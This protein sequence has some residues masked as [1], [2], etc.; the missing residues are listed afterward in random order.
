MTKRQKRRLTI[1]LV[2]LFILLLA[3]FLFGVM[4][5]QNQVLKIL[6]P[7]KYADYVYQYAEKNELDP[8]LVFAIIKAESNFKPEVISTSNAMGL[9]QLVDSTAEDTAKKL[10]IPYEGKETLLDPEKNIMLGTKY[11]TDLLAKYDNVTI[12]LTAYNAGSGNVDKWIA[13]GTIKEDGSNAENIPF[14]ETNHYV[15]KIL[16]DYQIYQN[17]YLE[18]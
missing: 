5:I 2:F 3:Y 9:M 14:K 18:K 12:A 15:R 13:N 1:G 6:Y 10:A 11:F 8:L 16:R 17:L 4:R 7:Q